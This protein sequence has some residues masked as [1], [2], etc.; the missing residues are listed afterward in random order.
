M[1][2]EFY[3]YGGYGAEDKLVKIANTIFKNGEVS[4][5]FRTTL[6]KPFIRKVSRVTFV[7]IE[8]LAWLLYDTNF[9]AGL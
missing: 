5:D 6:I 7:I 9:L 8:P 3:K 1:I 4:S 2:N